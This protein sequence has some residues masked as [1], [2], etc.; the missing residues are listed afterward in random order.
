MNTI[1]IVKDGIVNIGYV[2][3]FEGH[4]IKNTNFHL[5]T[6]DFETNEGYIELKSNNQWRLYTQIGQTINQ[7]RYYHFSSF[8][9]CLE[10]LKELK[11]DE[12]IV[13]CNSDDYKKYLKK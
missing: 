12:N 9:E 11:G 10:K 6:Y 5:I 3:T 8:N 1:Y 7:S 13:I 2:S 4:Q